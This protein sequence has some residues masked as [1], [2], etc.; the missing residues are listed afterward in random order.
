MTLCLETIVG[1]ANAHSLPQF[2]WARSVGLL[3]Y[4][5][6]QSDRRNMEP[7]N[8]VRLSK[9]L[10]SRLGD[11][12]A[13]QSVDRI[14]S[15]PQLIIMPSLEDIHTAIQLGERALASEEMAILGAGDGS[16]ARTWHFEAFE[17][18][19]G[20][21]RSMTSGGKTLKLFSYELVFFIDAH[22]WNQYL[23]CTYRTKSSQPNRR[24]ELVS[25]EASDDRNGQVPSPRRFQRV[26]FPWT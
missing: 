4:D 10:H 20:W 15:T 5:L 9:F 21:P 12:V 8:L 6:A 26:P 23:P 1:A 16:E 25:P 13:R 24:W 19:K 22:E 18:L 17:L 11:D 7:T 2:V 3:S 14:Q